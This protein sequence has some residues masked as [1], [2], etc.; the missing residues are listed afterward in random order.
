MTFFIGDPQKSVMEELPKRTRTLE[1]TGKLIGSFKEAKGSGQPSPEER[2]RESIPTFF[3]MMDFPKHP[4]T[5][6]ASGLHM[7]VGQ[8]KRTFKNVARNWS[9]S[10]ISTRQVRDKECSSILE[11]KDGRCNFAPPMLP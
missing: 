11:G 6:G 2:R 7:G 10:P 3:Q 9:L 5:V 8:L 1:P 4:K